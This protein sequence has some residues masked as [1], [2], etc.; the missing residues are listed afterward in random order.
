MYNYILPPR[1]DNVLYN[2][3]IDKEN[4]FTDCFGVAGDTE[5]RQND[6]QWR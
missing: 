4:H 2:T 1:N 5:G 3:F 6:D